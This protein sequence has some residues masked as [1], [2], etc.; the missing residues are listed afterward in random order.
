MTASWRTRQELE[1]QAVTLAAQGVSRRAIA[2][3]LGVSRNTLR[4]LLEVHRAAREHGHSAV[5][6]A[7]TAAPRAR[8]I[9]EW[10]TQVTNLLARHPTITAQRIFE[11]LRS[12]GFGGGYT[13]VKK[14]VRSVRPRPLATP[15][16]ATPSYGP[17]EMA[18][19]DWS[20][21]TL[22]LGGRRQIVQA[23][24][25]VL[26]HSRRKFFSLH[27]HAD[28][29]ALMAGHAAAFER[30]GG[31]A[32]CCKYDSQKPVVLR[33]GAAADLQSTLPRL[34]RA[35]RDEARRRA[36]RSSQRQ[37]TGRAQLL[38]ARKIVL[39]RSQLPRLR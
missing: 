2:R 12:A 17:G 5:E 27:E 39:Q 18:E 19:S 7:R 8:K 24:G 38:G 29:H 15:S 11:E 20:P 33:W 13:A 9:D 35:L 21:Y 10:T 31:L 14:H 32:Q 1:Q 34:R 25:Y 3:A 6:P 26:V 30:F 23:H 4:R 28:L 22:D 16:L 36:P 37:A